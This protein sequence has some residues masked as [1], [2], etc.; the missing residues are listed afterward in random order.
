MGKLYNT[1]TRKI[2]HWLEYTNIGYRWHLKYRTGCTTPNGSPN[3]PWHNGV[4]KNQDE[5]E[6]AVC[7]VRELRLPVMNDLPK[8][9]DSLAALDLILKSTDKN[10]KIFDAGGEMYSMI[11]PWLAMYGYTDLAAGNLILKQSIKKGPIRYHY[12][13]ITQTGLTAASYDAITCLSVIEHGVN[14]DAYFR[15]MARMLKPD[16]VLITSTDYFETPIDTKR[17]MAYG[18]P[19]KIFNK[20]AIVDAIAIA[21]QHGLHPTAPIDLSSDQAVVQWKAYN[22]A[23]TFAIF[24]LR[25]TE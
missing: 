25:K 24:S 18:A 22:L 12:A 7:Q 4:L 19:I 9:W 10:A 5:S 15:E 17:Q 6:K 1:V 8:N 20:A 23:Y 2:V 3:A 21:A 11:L 13:D 16:G 14:L